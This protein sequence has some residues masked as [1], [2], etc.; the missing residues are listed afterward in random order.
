MKN[1]F[2]NQT[3]KNSKWKK[4]LLKKYFTPIDQCSEVLSFDFWVT[5]SLSKEVKSS[6]KFARQIIL[7]SVKFARQIILFHIVI[8][9]DSLLKNN[10][11][12]CF[13]VVNYSRLYI[14][15]YPGS[16][17]TFGTPILQIFTIF[18]LPVIIIST[19]R[20]NIKLIIIFAWKRKLSWYSPEKE[21]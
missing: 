18:Y 2:F 10:K 12:D 5:L 6:V 16:F 13:D 3:L 11:K 14:Q 15:V 20:V 8:Y 4:L 19:M 1:T 7:S 9:P 17:I 21:S